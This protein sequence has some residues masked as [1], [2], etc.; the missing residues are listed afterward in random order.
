MIM[1][2]MVL[3]EMIYKLDKSRVKLK[4]NHPFYESNSNKEFW[5]EKIYDNRA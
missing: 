4:K 2:K 3:I 1:I 5:F